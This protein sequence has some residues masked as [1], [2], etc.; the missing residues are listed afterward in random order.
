MPLIADAGRHQSERACY[1]LIQELVAERYQALQAIEDLFDLE[2]HVPMP[3]AGDACNHFAEEY[4]VV[5]LNADSH[6]GCKP[7][8]DLEQQPA[9]SHAI[10]EARNGLDV[11]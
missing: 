4:A 5:N 8:V 10:H 9:I 3:F 1:G 6:A 11:A 7:F 2:F